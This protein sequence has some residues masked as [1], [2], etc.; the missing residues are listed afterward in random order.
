[1]L[2]YILAAHRASS[3]ESSSP[4]CKVP[5]R[6]AYVPVSLY[7]PMNGLSLRTV[8]FALTNKCVRSRVVFHDV[9]ESELLDS[10]SKFGILKDMVPTDMGGTVL[11]DRS[12]WIANR[13]ALEMEEI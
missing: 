7:S 2:R 5:E 1:M 11:L 10:L 6:V 13:R 3:F 4:V 9:P 12:E 8:L